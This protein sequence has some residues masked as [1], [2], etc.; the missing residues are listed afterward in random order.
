MRLGIN[1][2]KL[3]EKGYQAARNG[4]L[5]YNAIFE[6]YCVISEPDFSKVCS[7]MFS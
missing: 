7:M 5:A 4:V 3:G 6:A 2:I 1:G